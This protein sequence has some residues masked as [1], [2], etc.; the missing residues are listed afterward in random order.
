MVEQR[1]TAQVRLV[2]VSSDQLVLFPCKGEGFGRTDGS[3]DP[4]GDQ[5]GF[6]RAVA[7]FDSD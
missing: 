1:A 7:P 6:N 3:L 5:T 4:T 2:K